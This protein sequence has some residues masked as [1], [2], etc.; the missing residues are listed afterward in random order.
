MDREEILR[1]VQTLGKG[2]WYHN[3]YL[4]QGIYT[5]P[6]DPG[7]KHAHYL[8][9]MIRPYIPDDLT[10][11][12]VLDLGCWSGFFSL[13]MKKLGASIVIGIDE[14]EGRIEQARFAAEVL[15]VDVD[16]RVMPSYDVDKLNMEFD[17]I[18]FLG[19]LYHLRYPLYMLDKLAGMLKERMFFQCCTLLHSGGIRVQ[20]DYSREVF[21]NEKI[22]E[23]PGFPKLCFI[24]N[25]LEGD[26]TN[27]WCPN[28][29]CLW[30]MLRSAGY[31]NI[32]QISGEI[33]ICD[34]HR[35]AQDPNISNF[36]DKYYLPVDEA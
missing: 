29:A 30:A 3:I 34:S 14:L 24:E 35:C 28:E 26:H 2:Y 20:D 1:K 32:R 25:K 27:W 12:T 31:K 8:W 6:D 17:Y 15:H 23:H 19:L 10:G 36:P 5:A 9:K 11:K 7:G 16:Y 4:G 22:L 13:E 33:Y 18:L 21:V